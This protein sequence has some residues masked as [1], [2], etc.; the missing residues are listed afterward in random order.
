MSNQPSTSAAYYQKLRWTDSEDSESDVDN[1]QGRRSLDTRETPQNAR[2]G[3]AE[4]V[5]HSEASDKSESDN[6]EVKAS[7]QRRGR[8][9]PRKY[10]VKTQTKKPKKT[11]KKVRPRS[12]SE[13]DYDDDEEEEEEEE[14]EEK[15]EPS[16]KKGKMENGQKFMDV[17]DDYSD[18]ELQEEQE[19]K[20]RNK[21]ARNKWH[22]WHEAEAEQAAKDLKRQASM[23][24]KRPLNQYVQDRPSP[25]KVEPRV[26]K[27]LDEAA[28][29]AYREKRKERRQKIQN[30][31]EKC[32]Q[33][34][35]RMREA[36]LNAPKIPNMG[37][38]SIEGCPSTRTTDREG[39]TTTWEQWKRVKWQ[40]EEQQKKWNARKEKPIRVLKPRTGP[41]ANNGMY[42]MESRREMERKEEDGFRY[43]TQK[44]KKK[45]DSEDLSDD[46]KPKCRNHSEKVVKI[47]ED[48]FKDA[49]YLDVRRKRRIARITKLKPKQVTDWFA[50]NRRKFQQKFKNGKIT[51]LPKQMKALEEMNK[52]RKERGE[53]LKLRE[54]EE[55]D[56]EEDE[57]D[58]ENDD[59]SSEDNLEEEPEVD[60]GFEAVESERA[61]RIRQID[62]LSTVGYPVFP[63]P[64]SSR[65]TRNGGL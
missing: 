40:D 27:P 45:K 50:N 18:K 32:R 4:G 19:R 44:I 7:P 52:E 63:A 25:P 30:R 43:N 60:E 53:H 34:L 22:Q 35:Q 47:L 31:K 39:N 16:R 29:I 23:K 26:H 5:D 48:E 21:L 49:Q 64:K 38:G 11:A 2:N 65:T 56:E 54:P 37:R 61:A 57:E 55:S 41:A 51:E 8:G 59:E 6:E 3:S 36:K 46:E 17:E 58:Y 9:R 14:E 13:S 42:A 1:N 24:R 33:Q 28:L 20:E 62:Y 12:D 10:G 15:F